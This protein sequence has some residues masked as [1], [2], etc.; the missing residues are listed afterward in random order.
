MTRPSANPQGHAARKPALAPLT[1][2]PL[3]APPAPSHLSP[4]AVE[5]WTDVWEA[6]GPAYNVRT[7]ARV[8]ERYAELSARRLVLL[9]TLLEEGWTT[10]GSTGQ[11]AVH[12]AARILSDTESKLQ[13]LE[14]R[15]GLSPESRLRLGIA[16]V[17]RESKLS[18]FMREQDADLLPLE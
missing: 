5:V 10:V 1:A 15:L 3:A 12:P 4:E 6:G 9:A 7:D 14:D 8:V 18:A 16:A 13:S 11:L 2:A 17:E